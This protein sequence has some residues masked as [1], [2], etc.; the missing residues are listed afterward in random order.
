VLGEN[1]KQA[2]KQ[3][4]DQDACYQHNACNQQMEQTLAVQ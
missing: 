1:L 3:Q 2:R 4:M